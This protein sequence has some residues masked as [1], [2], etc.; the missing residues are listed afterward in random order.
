MK[1]NKRSTSASNA[2]ELENV[3][4]IKAAKGHDFANEYLCEFVDGGE[5]LWTQSPAKSIFG[6][7]GPMETDLK[8]LRSRGH[9]VTLVRVIL[10]NT[11][12]PL[13]VLLRF[14][15]GN[16][17]VADMEASVRTN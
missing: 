12:K 1:S 5:P 4:V 6:F 16:F 13:E 10:E 17:L 2:P 15:D 11:N 3:Y 14:A 7:K 8:H 9:Q